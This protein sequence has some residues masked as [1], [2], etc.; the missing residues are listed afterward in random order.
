MERVPE[1]YRDGLKQG[2]AG[3]NIS[4]DDHVVLGVNTSSDRYGGYICQPLVSDLI[5]EP[6]YSRLRAAGLEKD[7]AKHLMYAFHQGYEWFVTKDHHFLNQRDALEALCHTI[8]IR[9]PSE[10]VAE[11]DGTV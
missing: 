8:Q 4:Q 9:T 6:L 3:L 5:D 1:Q 10:L 2:L 7:D 11:L